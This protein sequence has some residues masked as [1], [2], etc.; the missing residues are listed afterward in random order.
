MSYYMPVRR[1]RCDDPPRGDL[2]DR[3][4]TPDGVIDDPLEHPAGVGYTAGRGLTWPHRDFA[5]TRFFVGDRPIC[6]PRSTVVLWRHT[7]AR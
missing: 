4:Q 5:G 7:V 3:W 1:S 6:N 2:H